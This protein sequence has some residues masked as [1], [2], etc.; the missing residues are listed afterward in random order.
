[1]WHGVEEYLIAT[2][3]AACILYTVIRSTIVVFF[4][5]PSLCSIGNLVH[6][7]WLAGWDVNWGWG[8]FLFTAGWVL[9]LPA[10]GVLAPPAL[11][12]QSIAQGWREQAGAEEQRR[13]LVREL[14][15]GIGR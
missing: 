10:F 11:V 12:L 13:R 15:A 6:E 1:M 7:A 8:P 4:A 9:A 3:I 5:G 14:K 2:F